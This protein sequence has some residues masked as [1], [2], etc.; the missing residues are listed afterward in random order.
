MKAC[1]ICGFIFIFLLNGFT[2]LSL[3]TFSKD[4][5]TRFSV[6]F[7]C[8]LFSNA[9]ISFYLLLTIRKHPGKVELYRKVNKETE[10]DNSTFENADLSFSGSGNN[11]ETSSVVID[12]KQDAELFR[13]FIK[14]CK[15]C[16]LEIVCI[17]YSE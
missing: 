15:I 17:N 11:F 13:T 1:D 6:I 14:E 7:H 12:D 4:F 3:C 8:L 9:I 2:M 10:S 16:N 5:F